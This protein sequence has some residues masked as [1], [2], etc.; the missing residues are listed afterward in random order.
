M[1]TIVGKIVNENK[2]TIGYKICDGSQVGDFSIK[3]VYAEYKKGNL[4]IIKAFDNTGNIS[5]NNIDDS[6]LP[7]FYNGI[8]INRSIAVIKLV[9]DDTD[10]IIGAVVTTPDGKLKILSLV[11]ILKLNKELTLYNAK[12]VNNSLV[13]KYGEFEVSGRFEARNFVIS[14]GRL[15]RYTGRG[16]KVQI[17]SYVTSIGYGAFQGCKSLTSVI[18]PDSVTSIRDRAFDECKNLTSVPIGN[19]VTSIGEFAFGSC[20]SLTSVIIGDG[21]TSIKGYV[22]CGCKNLTTIVIGKCLS[23][24]DNIP[25]SNLSKINIDSDNPYFYAEDNIVYS[26][27]GKTLIMSA[28]NKRGKIVG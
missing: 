25:V 7:V 22:F 28:R 19:S 6:L 1:Y 20:E 3:D 2:Q 23:N 11:N 24:L 8:C 27:D 17:P 9:K 18:I 26:K 12:V 13:S 21:M 16:R 15:V 14:N 5:L 10:N 4:P